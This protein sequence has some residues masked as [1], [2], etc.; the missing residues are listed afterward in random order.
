MS[1][2][3]SQGAAKVQP[4]WCH[5]VAETQPRDRQREKETERERERARE[6]ETERE[7]DRDRERE[8]ER[9]TGRSDS[10]PPSTRQVPAGQ[11][12]GSALRLQT[13][14]PAAKVGMEGGGGGG[15]G[16]KTR[17]HTAHST[18]S[19]Q[20]TTRTAREIYAAWYGRAGR[21]TTSCCDRMPC[22]RLSSYREEDSVPT[23]R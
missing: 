14:T 10:G 13:Q 20:H 23:T 4:R 11:W 21:A 2:R 17:K 8:R 9:A 18:H 5:D 12:Q 7:R 16:S 1:P 19:T 3:C 15:R 6:R 22:S